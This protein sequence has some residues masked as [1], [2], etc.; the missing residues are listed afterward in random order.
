MFFYKIIYFIGF[1][2]I[3]LRLIVSIILPI[4][5]LY[6]IYCNFI[7]PKLREK[8]ES[9]YKN[10][11]VIITGASSGIGAELAKKYARLGCKVTIVARRLDQLEKVK[12]SFLKDYSRV[13]DDDILVIKGDLT[14]ID[15]CKNMVEKVI[16]KWSKIDIC[17]WNAGS[18][19]LIEF[20]KLQGDISIYR[21]NM[22]LNYFSLVNCT[23]LVYKYLEQ[24]HGSIIVI[25]S[26]AGKFGT[27][28]RTS[29]SS[30]KHAVMGFFNSLRNE[31]KNIQITIVCPGFI[32]T[33]FHDNLKTLDGKQVE[34]N[35]GNFMTASQCANEIILAERQGIREL[36]QTAKGRV[37]NYLQAIFPE[38]IEFLT[39]KF[40]SSSVKK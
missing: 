17:V 9:S 13:N 34:R 38:L 8:P 19:S 31:T 23:H 2:Y 6:F 7:A 33:E 3:V 27:A 4:A 20:S 21:D 18:G 39:H 10:K 24:S 40:A 16:E 36:I 12:S 15:D 35:K 26:L 14:L 1:P 25:S 29:Y 37:G 11:V 32:L 28:L 30:S 5:S 22:E